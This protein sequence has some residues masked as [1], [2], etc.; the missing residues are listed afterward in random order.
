MKN[1]K[2]SII[3]RRAVPCRGK[4]DYVFRFSIHPS[5][6]LFWINLFNIFRDFSRNL[7]Q[8]PLSYEAMTL[9]WKSPTQ[10]SNRMKKKDN[11]YPKGQSPQLDGKRFRGVFHICNVYVCLHW[12]LGCALSLCAIHCADANMVIGLA[13]RPKQTHR[14][15]L[16]EV[17]SIWFQTNSIMVYL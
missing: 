12:T 13:C 6:F 4:E 7:V 9:L 17:V 14:D 1:Q 16:E 3:P 15:P 8:M 5:V 10:I 11:L 2:K